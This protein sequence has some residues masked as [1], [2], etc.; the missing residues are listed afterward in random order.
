MYL[1]RSDPKFVVF[2]AQVIV[3]PRCVD[4]TGGGG[5]GL[6]CIRTRGVILNITTIILHNNREE[7][8]GG[9]LKIR[10]VFSLSISPW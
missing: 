7:I 5:I 1:L 6:S 10:V 3:Y 4:H 2:C 9:G 8:A